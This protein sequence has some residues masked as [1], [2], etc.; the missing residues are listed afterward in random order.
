MLSPVVSLSL[1]CAVLSVH[2]NKQRSVKR[3]A[4]IC[5]SFAL[6]NT[7]I[8]L[9]QGDT[10]GGTVGRGDVAEVVVEAAL[11]PSAENTIFEVYGERGRGR[12]RDK[13]DRQKE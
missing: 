4:R 7:G 12:E 1:A 5:R 11:S 2:A 8:E 13:T 3:C 6:H 10:I 9:N